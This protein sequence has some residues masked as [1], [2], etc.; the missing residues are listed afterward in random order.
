M[1][2]SHPLVRIPPG[3]TMASTRKRSVGTKTKADPGFEFSE[4]TV[5]L[6]ASSDEPKSKPTEVEDTESQEEDTSESS[7]ARYGKLVYRVFI[8]TVDAFID[9]VESTS[10]LYRE[11]VA[12]LKRQSESEAAPERAE[13][14]PFARDAEGYGTTGESSLKKED[15]AVSGDSGLVSMETPAEDEGGKRR[16]MVEV[17]D[18]DS[19]TTV[20]LDADE[21]TPRS[22][23]PKDHK[24]VA[25]DEKGDVVI[26]VLHIAPTEDEKL[27]AEFEAKVGERAKSYTERPTR[28]LAALYYAFLAHFEYVVF[29]LI[30]MNVL[31]NGSVL[32]LVYAFLMFLWGLLSIP[33]PT[34]SFWLTLIFYTMVVVTLKYAFQFHDINYPGDSNGGLYIP[35]IIGIEYQEDYFS[36]VVWDLFLLI[37][38]LFHRGLLI[39]SQLNSTQMTSLLACILTLCNMKANILIITSNYASPF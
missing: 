10:A 18:R 7:L 32:S 35:V 13:A 2:S 1:Q 15:A 33:W 3:I 30:I 9:W 20:P 22:K 19:Y 6:T 11:V 23:P 17:H 28:L 8:E 27:I 34:R 37:A 12:E 14:Y 39:V 24:S 38:L 5:S 21:T 31:V 29:F 4:E 36:N 26:E 25:F 16:V